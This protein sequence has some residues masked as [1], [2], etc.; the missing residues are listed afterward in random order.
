MQETRA[1]DNISNLFRI[2]YLGF[3]N[4][5]REDIIF[6]FKSHFTEFTFVY[7]I[8]KVLQKLLY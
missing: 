5:K 3:L 2:I 7:C 4:M 1:I 8:V 6:V